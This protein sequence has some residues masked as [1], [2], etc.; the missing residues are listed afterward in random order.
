MKSSVGNQNKKASLMLLSEEATNKDTT[1]KTQLLMSFTN[2]DSKGSERIWIDS[3]FFGDQRAELTIQKATFPENFL[4]YINQA[5]VSLVKGGEKAV[6][7]D[8]VV[9][10]QI[11]PMANVDPAINLDSYV[12]KQNEVVIYCPVYNTSTGL[13]HGITKNLG[14]ITLRGD[15]KERFFSYGFHKGKSSVLYC[16]LKT[17]LPNLFSCTAFKNHVPF[18][19]DQNENKVKSTGL[20]IFLPSTLDRKEDFIQWKDHVHLHPIGVTTDELKDVTGLQKINPAILDLSD[21]RE[22]HVAGYYKI[23][24]KV[25]EISNQNLIRNSDAYLCS[26][27]KTDPDN[28][29]VWIDDSFKMSSKKFQLTY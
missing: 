26:G 22:K 23:I 25:A 11:M 1:L 14:L 12:P 18:L 28:E 10:A 9:T 27:R 15:V 4:C 13:Y 29:F 2:D 6:Y 19:L 8:Y 21:E 24:K 7:C 5:T 17:R 3:G 16:S 20:F